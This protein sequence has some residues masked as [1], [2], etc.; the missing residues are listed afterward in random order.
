MHKMDKLFLEYIESGE[1]NKELQATVAIL[2]KFVLKQQ[3]SSTFTVT[4]TYG[5]NQHLSVCVVLWGSRC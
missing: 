3:K 4:E 2:K 1:F 5:K